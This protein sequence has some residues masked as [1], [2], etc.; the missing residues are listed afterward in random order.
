MF[1][2][3]WVCTQ[4]CVCRYMN[5]CVSVYVYDLCQC[6]MYECVCMHVIVMCVCVNGC[7]V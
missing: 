3:E 6:V 7:D 4:K 5:T 1:V 2:Y